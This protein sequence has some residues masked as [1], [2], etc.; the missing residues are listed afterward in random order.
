MDN[1]RTSRLGEILIEKGLLT[2]AQLDIAI[3]EQ[4]S[5]RKNM[6]PLDQQFAAATS[7]GE[8]LIELGFIDRLQL[9]RGLNWQA[10]LRKMTM[11]MAFCA[12][13]MSFAPTAAAAPKASSSSS[14]ATYTLPLTIQ[15][16]N[17]SSMFGM[18]AEATSDVGGGK[19]MAYIDANDWL[20]YANT[21]F[22]APATGVYK[23][24][25][26]VASPGGGGSFA[27]TESDGSIK[28]DTVSV[29]S[30]GGSQKWVNVERTITMV[31][32]T[33]SLGITALV[34]GSGFNINWFKV[35]YMGSP[36][37]V[38]IQAEDY[39]SM[40]GIQTQATTDTGGGLNVGYIDASDWM[41]YSKSMIYIPTA[42]SYNITYRVASPGG[43]G[44]FALAEADGSVTYDTVS[45]PN[46]GG[47]QTWVSVT[48]TVN[49]TAGAHSFKITALAR[50][51]GFNIN[52]F[53]VETPSGGAV[54]S[55]SS[56]VA[57]SAPASSSSSSVASSVVSSTSSSVTSS[58]VSSSTSSLA[59]STPTSSSSSSAPAV[60][61]SSSSVASS[62]ASS[63]GSPIQSTVSGAVG[64]SWVAP[65]Q[66]ENGTPLD[67]T[68]IGGYEFRYRNINDANYTYVTINDPWMNYYNFNY[69]SGTYIFQVATY[70]TNG[71]YSN[72]IDVIPK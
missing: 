57:S 7:L 64:F 21:A 36:L 23:I 4:R 27:L 19:D 1:K 52:W 9:N 42:G 38:T 45:V 28:Y 53:K 39:T 5:R 62:A 69:L 49:L 14:T 46:T 3:K 24:T 20:K 25:Y 29:P 13:F 11:A 44:S 61:S 15:A 60:A 68:Q 48:R 26:R 22:V 34:R 8:I 58:A 70:D 51:Y 65:T 41:S 30:T 37:P 71:L 40:S 59:S 12:P 33:H 32:G 2:A 17:Y 54:S 35:E 10:L 50:G 47:W 67:I 16:E 55:S 56:S 18:Q 66:R 31:A 63:S 43:G 6:D 72:F